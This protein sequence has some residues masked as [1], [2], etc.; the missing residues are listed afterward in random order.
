MCPDSKIASK[1]CINR[2]KAT[3]L[4]V[5]IL[6]PANLRD[7]SNNLKHNHFSLIIDETTDI[8][9]SKSL[10]LLARYYK[11]NQ[12]VERFLD[13]IEVD[14][15]TAECL[16]GAIM[17]VMLKNDIPFENIIGFGADNCS[18]MMGHLT[19]MK[20]LFKSVNPNIVIIG[21][22]CHSFH[23]CSSAACEKLP[24]SIEQFSRDVYNYFSNS[25]KRCSQFK[26]CQ[27]VLKEKT[28]VILRPS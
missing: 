8:N 3:Q 26:D 10:A 18:V 1:L 11:N 16:F 14:K 20:A 15:A 7:F 6:G 23:L 19:A 21:C 4:S 9:T 12:I 27:I 28:N 13:L 17:D 24:K 5:E 22:T 25:L 2:K